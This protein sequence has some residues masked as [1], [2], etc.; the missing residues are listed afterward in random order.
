MDRAAMLAL[1]ASPDYSIEW[2]KRSELEPRL[3]GSVAVVSTHWQGRGAYQGK[4]FVDDQRCSV[5][6]SLD[7]PPSVIAEHCTN[8]EQH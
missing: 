1:L 2:G 4:P 3:S 6:V 8:I 7:G 5:I